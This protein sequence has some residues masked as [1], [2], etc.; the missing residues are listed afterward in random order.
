M[1]NR[2]VFLVLVLLLVS[3]TIVMTGYFMKKSLFDSPFRTTVIAENVSISSEWT[4]LD[5]KKLIRIEGD[6]QHLT[7]NISEPFEGDFFNK[8]IRSPDGQVFNVDA[9]LVDDRGE[10]YLLTYEGFLGK[11]N[12]NY[13]GGKF[14]LPS[15]KNYVQ[16]LLRSEIP[17]NVRQVL[18]IYYYSSDL[19]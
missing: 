13:S 10:E 18:W 16:L 8:G 17:I 2:K 7:L 12:V 11:W 5:T 14:G 4:Q 1:K 15:D 9:K 6:F 3:L 19:R